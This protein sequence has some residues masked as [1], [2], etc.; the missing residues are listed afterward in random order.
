MDIITLL[1]VLM[2]LALAILLFSGFPVV[3]KILYKQSSLI[4]VD[5]D[6][7]AP[8]KVKKTARIS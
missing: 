7:F 5:N 2:F 6:Y 3:I 1:P 4:I 8:Q